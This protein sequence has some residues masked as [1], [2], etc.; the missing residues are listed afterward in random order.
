[1]ERKTN[2]FQIKHFDDPQLAALRQLDDIAQEF[3]PANKT[4]FLS[5]SLLAALPNIPEV[6]TLLR[7]MEVGN[8]GGGFFDKPFIPLFGEAKLLVNYE[9]IYEL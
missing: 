8:E 7:R 9:K 4:V 1:M 2:S 6:C 5:H 3:D